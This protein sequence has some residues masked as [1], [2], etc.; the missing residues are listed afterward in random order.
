MFVTF[1][2]SSVYES[3]LNIGFLCQSTSNHVVRKLQAPYK[4]LVG[5]HMISLLSIL[6]CILI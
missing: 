3:D 4:N 6:H 2:V 1:L 5:L